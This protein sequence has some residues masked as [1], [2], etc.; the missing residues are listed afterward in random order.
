MPLV[1]VGAVLNREASDDDEKIHV[2][3]YNHRGVNIGL[4]VDRILDT[5][6]DVFSVQRCVDRPGIVGSAV[7]QKRV[8]DFLDADALIRAS[9]V[10]EFTGAA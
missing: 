4:V 2:V 3:V 7:V 1:R 10:I 9:Q 8:T 6:D 5:V